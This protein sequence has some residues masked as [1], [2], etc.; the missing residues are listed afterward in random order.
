M[1]Y[2]DGCYTALTKLGFSSQLLAKLSPT[3]KSHLINAGVGAAGGAVLGGEDSRMSGALGGAALGLGAGHLMGQAAEGA[4]AKKGLNSAEHAAEGAAMH[5]PSGEYMP[6]A[7]EGAMRPIERTKFHPSEAGASVFPPGFGTNSLPPGASAEVPGAMAMRSV[8]PKG[9]LPVSRKEVGLGELSSMG[10]ARPP[11]VQSAGASAEIAASSPLT[12]PFIDMLPQSLLPNGMPEIP[13]AS[14]VPTNLGPVVPGTPMSMRELSARHHSQPVSGMQPTNYPDTI[15]VGNSML[16]TMQP[17]AKTG[18]VIS[19]RLFLPL[20][21]MA[22]DPMLARMLAGGVHGAG[23][24][25]LAGAGIASE[26]NRGRGALT[27]ALIGGGAGVL[28][29]AITGGSL[30][31]LH[32]EYRGLP[33][34]A[35]IKSVTAPVKSIPPAVVHP[36]TMPSLSSIPPTM[37]PSSTYPSS[38]LPPAGIPSTIPPEPAMDAAAAIAK[39]KALIANSGAGS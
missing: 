13:K 21:K 9:M 22:M 35:G 14:P 2:S 28:G 6:G 18:S 36:P 17:V 8:S 34:A 1:Y 19:P 37:P 7:V 20:T 27:G 15:P 11:T 24:G 3:A 25:G 30:G 33:S 39:L 12:D 16:P 38:M 26:D 29:G 32:G 31:V 4:A 5:R 23:L 10:P